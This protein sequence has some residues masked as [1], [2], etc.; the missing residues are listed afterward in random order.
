MCHT[1]HHFWN[2]RSTYLPILIKPSSIPTIRGA[3]QAVQKTQD[4]RKRRRGFQLPTLRTVRFYIF[5]RGSLQQT[6]LIRMVQSQGYSSSVYETRIY[7]H[8][9]IDDKCHPNI[10][11]LIQKSVEYSVRVTVLLFR[12]LSWFMIFCFEYSG[13]YEI[14]EAGMKERNRNPQN[15][16]SG[17]SAAAY[18]WLKSFV[19][20]LENCENINQQTR[21][22][23]LFVE[24]PYK[25]L[26]GL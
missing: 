19:S 25:L 5:Q 21:S 3:K 2:S 16:R 4:H 11:E 10:W 13:Q 7:I 17:F 20:K 9:T 6:W 26:Y 22:F 24:Y 8:N 23:T 14:E 18:I 12:N 1:H 15:E